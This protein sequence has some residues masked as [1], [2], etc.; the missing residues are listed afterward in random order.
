MRKVLF[1][2]LFLGYL[3][4]NGQL[5]PLSKSDSGIIH[6]NL[7]KY[8]F[9]IA[10]ND[11]RGASGALN[12]VAFVF[13]NNNHY[14]PAADY[15]EKS[16]ILNEKVAN[17]NGV[18][19][20][21]NNLGMLY[22]DIGEYQKSLDSFTKTLAARR[23]SKEPVGVISALINMSVVLNNM[24]RYEE[25]IVNLSEA[26]DIS[27]ELYD[28]H[29]MRSVYGMLSETYEKMGMIDKSLQYFSLY[30]TFHEEIQREEVKSINK[31]L[32]QEKL[33]KQVIEAEKAK[34]E[35]ELLRKE[36]EIFQQEQVI[37]T[38]DSINQG[39]YAD[40]TKNQ[41]AIRL[42]EQEKKLSEMEANSREQQNLQLIRDRRN[43][44]VIAII[45]IIA[46]VIISILIAINSRKTRIHAKHLSEKNLS[47]E[48]QKVELQNANEVKDRIF[49]IIAHDMRSPISA[50][51]GFFM[52]L[53][54]YDLQEE[55][56]RALA[57]VESQLTN[58]ATLLE[59]LLTWSKSQIQNA[60]PMFQKLEVKALVEESF[61][62]L[63]W[64]AEKKNIT[65]VNNVKNGD[66]IESDKEMLNIVIR[67]LIQNAIKFTPKGG[68]VY[69]N[70]E[71][72]KGHHLLKVQDTGIGMDE[73]KMAK[74]FN[75]HTNRSSMGTDK[76]RGSGL[77]LILCKE[78]IE[79]INGNIEVSSAPGAGS[80]FMLK[81]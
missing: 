67:N 54:D 34:K 77:G 62:L 12:D 14:I 60:E 41:I 42:L 23:A 69:V 2:I 52:I 66:F 63:R 53:D 80:T 47:I 30:K 25:S 61:M 49:S 18:A 72:E 57:S 75:I 21:N 48:M 58:S 55:L 24:Q 10:K 51:Q 27:R 4:S 45:I 20:I 46:I 81:F 59:N 9:L 56:R 79:K 40:L 32:A 37:Q 29:Q 73:E 8:E 35:N 65:L 36:L 7:E 31:E 78:L 70:F 17:E 43:V 28:K 3:C 6:Q 26:L 19:M 22:S 50:L 38:K 68:K 71:M 76:E 1:T 16:L 11:L 33:Q 64:Q 5:H 13:W 74:L 15:Y 39:L 44:L